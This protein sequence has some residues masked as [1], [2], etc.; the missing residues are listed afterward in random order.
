MIA[1]GSTRSGHRENH[2]G[3]RDA[4]HQAAHS[5]RRANIPSR[6][7]VGGSAIEAS[8]IAGHTGL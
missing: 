3:T 1:I 2:S 7:E 6:Q 8:K 4:L 5:F